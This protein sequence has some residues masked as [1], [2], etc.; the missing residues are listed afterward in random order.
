MTF[1]LTPSN[2]RALERWHRTKA[3]QESL[4]GWQARLS[5]P[6][7]TALLT[8]CYAT[9]LAVAFACVLAF[10]VVEPTNTLL[11]IYLA[12]MLIAMVAFTSVRIGIGSRD[13]APEIVLDD[14]E[15]EVLALWRGRTATAMSVALVA[16]GVA[17]ACVFPFFAT[18]ST[19][20]APVAVTAGLYM[21]F[22]YLAAGTLP[23]VGY[24]ATF[25]RNPEE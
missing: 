7:S 14:Y 8:A 11:G 6:R 1:A 5:N 4:A 12:A 16:G 15:H 10:N 17:L 18:E 21:I 20:A 3:R 9:A 23:T 22:V 13:K 2:Q 19:P 24:A 25:N